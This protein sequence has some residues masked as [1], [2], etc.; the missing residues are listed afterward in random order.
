VRKLWEANSQRALVAGL[1]AAVF[2][3]VPL[4]TDTFQTFQFANVA[5]FFIAI[6]GLNLLTGCSGQISLGNSA[7]MAIGGYATAL[8][9]RRVGV[10]S[11][12]TLP[13]SAL[14][15]GI[16]GFLF[17]IPA[18]RLRGIYLALA[19]FALA[20]AVTPVLNNYDSFTGGH[21]GINLAPT[22]PPP[23]LDLSNEQWLYFLDWG[24]AGLLFVPALLLLRT[25]TGRAWTAIRDSP[26]AAVA[27]GVNIAYYK[28]LAFGIS[29]LYAGVAGSLQVITLTYVNPDSY[30]LNLSLEL[31]I[32]TVIGGLGS[33]W[34]PMFGALVVVW[35]PYLAEKA[36]NLHV[37]PLTFGGKPDIGFGILLVV[38]LLFAPSGVAGLVQQGAARYRGLRV[39]GRGEAALSALVPNLGP[40]REEEAGP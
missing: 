27:S 21:A 8:L 9:V 15:A 16:T 14:L 10:P 35:L 4:V 31:L 32:G 13:F 18:L 12:L 17:G 25:R 3:A 28:A 26:T 19:T 39:R 24:V 22:V 7:F 20:L 29:A 36:A 40:E 38:I 2:F 23:G 6:V 1:G 30:S 5:I 33:A 11:L 34:G 37:G